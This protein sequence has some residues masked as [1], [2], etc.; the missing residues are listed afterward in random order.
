MLHTLH[1]GSTHRLPA[2]VAASLI[3]S[4]RNHHQRRHYPSSPATPQQGGHS[5]RWQSGGG[6]Y[7]EATSTMP[8]A[9]AAAAAD[10][11][12]QYVVLRKDLWAEQKW[13]L[14]SLVA[15]ACH[16]STAAMWLYKDDTVTAAYLAPENVDH[17]HKAGYRLS[18]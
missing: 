11:V 16:A 1:L 2:T 7:A 12:V 10:P 13:P 8:A 5:V 3:H 17:M 9:A 18:P 15:Q 14:G 6:M 4:A